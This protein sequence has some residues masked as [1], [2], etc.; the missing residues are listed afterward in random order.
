MIIETALV[1]LAKAGGTELFISSSESLLKK[2]KTAKDIKQLFINTG[3]F[4]VDYEND[5]DQLFDDM[6]NVLSKENMTK[7]ANELKDEPGYKLKDRILN[8]LMGIM[9]EYEIPH[10]MALSYANVILFAIMGQLPVV[11][12]DKY[13][14]AY[15]AEWKAEQEESFKELAEKFERL[16]NEL[17]IYQ[18]RQLEILSADAID[19]D[20]R[21]QT[22]DPKIGF[23]FFNVLN[24]LEEEQ[25]NPTGLME[26]FEN[27]SSDFLFGRNDYIEILWGVEEF[28]V[29]REYASRAYAWLLYLDNLSFEYKSNSPK[30][31]FGKLLCT[32]HNFSAFSKSNDKI[33]I[34]AKALAK[35]KNAWDHIFG[36][37]P[38]GHASIFGDLHAPK[39]RNHV[40]ED[41]ITRKEMYDTNLGYIDLLLKATDFKPQRWNDL[42]SIYDEVDPDIRK[43]IKEKLLFEIAQMD[44]DERLII[45][46]NIRRVVYKHRYFASAEWTMGED[47]IGEMLDILDSIN[48]TQQEYDFE[49]LFRPSYDGIILD[50]VPYDVDDK[51][52]INESKTK[53]LLVK[54]INEF[55]ENNYSLELLSKLCAKEKSSYLGRVLSDYWDDDNFDKNVFA[56]LY[57][58][59]S[60]HE[61]AIEYIEGLA[62]RGVD[63]Y[64]NVNEL[65]ECVE[66]DDDFRII[67]FRI[68]ALYTDKKPLV[69][70][71]SV[72]IKRAFWKDFRWLSSNNMDW[73][74]AECQ[75]YGTV[76]SYLDL[77]YRFHKNRNLTPEQ[78]LEKMQRI[79]VMERGSINS[80]TDHYLKE[81]LKPLQEQ[82]I[83][84]RDKCAKIAHIEIAFFYL[85]DWE[86]MKCFQKE[87][88]HDPE[89]YAEMVSVI[90]RHDGDDPE[91]RKTE[92]F[93]NYAQVI[94]RL[95]DMAK[96]CPC[97]ENGTVSYDE[98]KVWVD[99]LIRILDSNHQKEMF[100]YVL[101]RLFAYAPK[102][103]DGHYPCEAV[104]QIIEE[105]GDE[106]LLSEYRC[107][108]FN[109]RGIFSP[110]AGRAEKDIAEGYKDN[111]DFLS[112]KY[113]KTADVFF[114]MSQRYVYDSDLERRRAEN[115][116]F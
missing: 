46:N 30:D 87:I 16:R 22:T 57:K 13:D 10:G 110:S 70:N 36:A 24:K 41:T 81:L 47:L 20:I 18:S 98:I 77:L 102:T 54:K 6:A 35:D 34:A 11:A 56:S 15:Q 104:C 49:Y 39:Y 109:K 64:T 103:A 85:L 66:L 28:L 55:K 63:V 62:R 40:E 65:S 89:M 50:P 72:E 97:E 78:L 107:E 100:G 74:V 23:D 7:L 32:W 76:N 12:P 106:S 115:G 8:S 61:M 91:E 79:D 27:Q 68:E 17:Q 59:Q 101:G 93:R 75:Q 80:M 3:E 86:D 43:K 113:P 112:I 67:L 116:Y 33:E 90:F 19:L 42:L 44:D 83:E 14:R 51:R 114:K 99:K 108:L 96:F 38:T 25:I 45:K 52:D 58:C 84:D 82:C 111:A 60:K 21:R 5:A 94:H 31:I 92:E 69:D 9:K 71:A 48:F 88:K 4:F 1:E 95:F 37:L 2:V 53:D 105:Y 26:L 73:A 29:Q